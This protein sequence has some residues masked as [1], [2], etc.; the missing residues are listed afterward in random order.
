MTVTPLTSY[1]HSTKKNKNK[2]KFIAVHSELVLNCQFTSEIPKGHAFFRMSTFRT[3]KL[4]CYIL[5]K[6][7]SSF[8]VNIADCATVSELREKIL[9]KNISAVAGVN[10]DQL[11][12]WKVCPFELLDL[13]QLL[14]AD[15][16]YLSTKDLKTQLANLQLCDG[17]A[18]DGAV[19]LSS[20]FSDACLGQIHVIAEV[21]DGE[22]PI[23]SFFLSSL[24]SLTPSVSPPVFLLHVA[25]PSS[26]LI[27]HRH[28][29]PVS[30]F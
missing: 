25:F 17:S 27:N 26:T 18:L 23:I 1:Q 30:F 9:L 21:S 14:K 12:I 24:R 4:Y 19:L 3:G 7:Q 6:S 22:Y 10:E 5:R 28:H 2:N 16:H 15:K 13:K 11:K 20:E 8:H 29:L